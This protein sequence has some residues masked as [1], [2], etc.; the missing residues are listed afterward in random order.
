MRNPELEHA[1]KVFPLTNDRWKDFETLFGSRG[2]CGGCWCMAWRLSPKDFEKNKG[3]GNKKLMHDIVKSG[4]VPGLLAYIHQVPAG[5]IALAPRKA[6]M[7]LENSR[8]LAAPDTQEVYSIPCFF[9][10]KEFRNRGL[11]H[12][13]LH[14]AITYARTRGIHILEGY[15]QAN[16]DTHLPAPFVWTGLESA[17][18]KAG[19]R[20]VARRSPKRP[21]MRYEIS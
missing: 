17:F 11:Q 21:I 6:F 20:E 14:A 8:V 1:W 9:I 4:E 2:A 7:K 18:R 16:M 19:F 3:A 5:W 15:P 13:L 12:A 10:A